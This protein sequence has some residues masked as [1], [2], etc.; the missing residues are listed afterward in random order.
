MNELLQKYVGQDIG[1]N[2]KEVKKYDYAKLLTVETDYFTVQDPETN[3]RYSYSFRWLLNVVE[4]EGGISTVGVFSSKNFPVCIEV[5]H[6]V[7]YSGAGGVG[8]SF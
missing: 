1:I 6:L 5:F 7:V 4:G 2:F 3:I 8:I